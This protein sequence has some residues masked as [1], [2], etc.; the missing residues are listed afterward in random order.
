MKT[1]IENEHASQEP[2]LLTNS[3]TRAGYAAIIRD[4]T[5]VGLGGRGG[6]FNIKSSTTYFLLSVP[7]S[8]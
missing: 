2:P 4:R 1:P 6:G 7:F 5:G 3:T 8:V